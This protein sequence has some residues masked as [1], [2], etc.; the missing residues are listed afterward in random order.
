MRIAADAAELYEESSPNQDSDTSTK[1]KRVSQ[2]APE[3]PLAY[4]SCWYVY[5]CMKVGASRMLL[6]AV[7]AIREGT[8]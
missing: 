8:S 3:Y 6:K 1:R 2:S 5:A 7:D 4:A